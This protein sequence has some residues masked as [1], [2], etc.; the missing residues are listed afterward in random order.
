MIR[1]ARLEDLPKILEIYAI[2]RGFMAETG[3]PTQWGSGYPKE[4]LLR[5]DIDA[6][7]LYVCCD[8]E[9]I[10]GVFMFFIGP[11]PTYEKIEG[12]WLSDQPY[13]TIH[14]IASDRSRKG[15]FDLCIDYCMKQ[16]NHLRIDTHA[17]NRVMQHLIEKRG[18]SKCG[19]VY[20]ITSD[21]TPRTA[22]EYIG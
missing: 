19:T 1:H 2:A 10:F 6:K 17:D 18:F 9:G 22:Y 13:G 14:R 20:M 4:E 12:K 7:Q 5:I 21:G 11:E 3:N 8:D 15:V 16:I